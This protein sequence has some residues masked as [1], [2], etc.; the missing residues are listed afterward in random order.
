[1]VKEP[2]LVADTKPMKK[3][4]PDATSDAANQIS[5]CLEGSTKQDFKAHLTVLV[6]NPFTTGSLT[7]NG[8][9]IQNTLPGVLV[10]T[11]HTLHLLLLS[12]SRSLLEY[13]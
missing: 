11:P 9:H 3:N 7:V 13:E 5:Q 4:V 1:M 10:C 8:I 2:S 12:L 6:L